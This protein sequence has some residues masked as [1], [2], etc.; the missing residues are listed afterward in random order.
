MDTMPGW[1]AGNRIQWAPLS[2]DLNWERV[3]TAVDGNRITLDAPLTTSLDQALGEGTV[4]RYEFP[5][6]IEHVGVENLRCVSVFERAFPMDEEH[7]WVC[8]SLDKVANAW[9]RQLTAVHFV[10]YVVDAQA[11]SKWLTIEDCTAL[12]PVSELGGYR[13]RVFSIGGQLTLVQRCVSER[14]LRD[15]T[16]GF[17]APGP[18]VFLHCMARDA[19]GPSG[20]VESWASG[21]LYDNVIIRGNALRFVNRGMAGQGAGWTTAN[22]LLWNCESTELQVQS[23]PGAQNQAYGCKGLIVDDSVNYDPRFMPYRPFVKGSA[24]EPASLYLTQLAARKGAGAPARLARAVISSSSSGARELTTADIAPRVRRAAGPPL[25]VEDARFTINGKPAGSTMTYSW[26]MGQMPRP[27]SQGF[28]PAITRFSPGEYGRG[29]TSVLE[30]MVEEM[31]PGSAFTQHYGLWYDRRRVNHNFYGSPE[32]DADDVTPPFMEMPWARSGQGRDW[33]G[34]SKYDLTRFNPWYFSR[35]KEFA[36]LCDIH[37]RVLHHLFYF[38]HALQE[39]RAHYVDFPWRP[40]NCIQDTDMPDENPAGSSFYDI[41]HPVRRDLHRRYIRHCLDVLKDNTNVVHG[42]DREYSGP[43]SFVRFW[44]DT[45]A[46]WEREN[47]RNLFILLEVPKTVIDAVLDNP[48]RRP[49]V[50]AIGFH[51]WFYRPDGSLFAIEGGINQA[52]REQNVNIL[53]PDDVAALQAQVNYS[54]NIVNTPE[55]QRLA[56]TIRAGTP[57]L[58]YRATREYRDAFPDLVILQQKDDFPELTSAIEKAIPREDRSK[59][60]PAPLVRNQP[61]TAWCMA[62][63]GAAYLVYSMAG[64]AVELDLTHESGRFTLA[65]LDSG[66]ANLRPAA[67]PVTAGRSVSLVPPEAGTGRPWVAWLA[68]H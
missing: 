13:R 26:Y 29:A 50:T 21:V 34:L 7:A 25:R 32:L 40:V 47:N 35:V 63:P 17:A 68:R 28:G 52:P 55:F 39:T 62:A 18:N 36:D 49:Q 5:G 24:V 37:G 61:T 1:R 27:L 4:A 45:V 53:P 33:N 8:V 48:V 42:I 54:G 38:Q 23:P 22:S 31:P 59:T 41:S 3:V 57:A 6:R 60:R 67:D 20:P 10:S 46:E 43:L 19:L 44:I 56:Q 16:T 14:G 66:C 15:F 12:D 30:E 64:K 51:H 65:W 9:V 11:D 58:R 2:R